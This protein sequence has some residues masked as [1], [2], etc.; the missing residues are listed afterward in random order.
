MANQVEV[1]NI[2]VLVLGGGIAGVYAAIKAREAGAA[3]VLLLDKGYIGKSGASCFAAG[4][5]HHWFP[6]EDLGDR[7][8]RL[9]RAQEYLAQQD[10][11]QDHLE[12][13]YPIVAEMAEYGVNWLKGPGGEVQRG[14]GRGSYPVIMFHGTDMMAA[15][16]KAAIRRGVKHLSKLVVTDLLVNQ[17]RAIGAVGFSTVTGDFYVFKARAV[18]MALGE[19]NYKGRTPHAKESTGDGY[20]MAYRAGALLNGGESLDSPTNV[21]PARYSIGPGMN[22]WMGTGAI[23]LN[24]KGERFME[25]YNPTLKERAGLRILAFAFSME[26]K[27]DNT[28]I[29][30]DMTHFTPEQV[31]RVKWTLPLSSLM[32]E[33]A[34]YL[35]GEKFVKPIEWQPL[36]P[37]ARPGLVVNRNFETSLP[38]LFASGEAAEVHAVIK[39]IAAAAT[40]GRAAG[41]NAARYAKGLAKIKPEVDPAQ[42]REL[43]ENCLAPLRSPAGL[44]PASA[45]AQVQRVMTPYQIL[46]LREGSRMRDALREIEDIRDNVLPLIGASDPHYLRYAHEAKHLTQVAEIHLRSAIMRE[47]T[48]TTLREDAPYR[49]NVNWLKWVRVRKGDAGMILSTED[50]PLGKYPLKVEMDRTLNHMWQ[51]AQK[52]GIVDIENDVVKWKTRA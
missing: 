14:P 6:D 17:G 20:A 7:V 10:M 44:E 21:F 5:S 52:N 34:G 47:E 39:G 19:A 1:D 24:S 51:V 49:D 13:S 29:Y 42:V 4:V 8:R 45:A 48:R 41:I 9:V 30:C 12:Q 31:S 25:K 40:A 38:G 23:F 2:D 50:V 46:L 16:A 32:M 35:V 18:V 22:I 33:R 3:N 36:P 27:Q 15:M 26:A 28:P 43:E 11:I 37:E